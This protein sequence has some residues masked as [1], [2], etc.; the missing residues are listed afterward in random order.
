MGMYKRKSLNTIGVCTLDSPACSKSLHQIHHPG[1]HLSKYCTYIWKMVWH[2]QTLSQKMSLPVHLWYNKSCAKGNIIPPNP[3]VTGNMFMSRTHGNSNF[4]YSNELLTIT[5]TMNFS[6]CRAVLH[7]K[8]VFNRRIR[9][10][11]SNNTQHYIKTLYYPLHCQISHCA[12]LHSNT[13]LKCIWKQ[14]FS[15]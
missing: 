1:F 12:A 6:R 13:L 9:S 4:S 2:L 11:K 3:Y 10:V 8:T 14:S 7:Y 5:I 15:T